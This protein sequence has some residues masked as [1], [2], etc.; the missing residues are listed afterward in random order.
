MNY[1]L[2]IFYL[3]PH[4]A[5]AIKKT[6]MFLPGADGFDEDKREQQDEDGDWASDEGDHQG[7]SRGASLKYS[8]IQASMRCITNL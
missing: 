3:K 5:L 6:R 1:L 8:N 7:A 2:G 4:E